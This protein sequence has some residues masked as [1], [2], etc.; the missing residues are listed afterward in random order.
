MRRLL[1][2]SFVLLFLACRGSTVSGPGGVPSA[3]PETETG[4]TSPEA[5]EVLTRPDL[6]EPMRSHAEKGAGMRDA[7]VGAN[8]ALVREL[9]AWTS[10]SMDDES[11]P[12][13]R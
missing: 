11:L 6:P 2:A 10:T 8:L 7:L 1:A 4:V 9:A 3:K 12:P 5:E 13:A